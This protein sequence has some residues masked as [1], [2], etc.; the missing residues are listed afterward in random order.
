MKLENLNKA[1]TLSR[2]V[3]RLRSLVQW[4]RNLDRG[5]AQMSMNTID[6]VKSIEITFDE[7]DAII[8]RYEADLEKRASEIGVEL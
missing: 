4:R 7:A 6:G 3:E 2:D 1:Q 5:T 8:D